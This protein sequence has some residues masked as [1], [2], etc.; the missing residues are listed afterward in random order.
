MRSAGLV[1]CFLFCILS[2][3]FALSARALPEGTEGRTGQTEAARPTAAEPPV[4][5]LAS[6]CS[7]TPLL[8]S[9]K[10]VPSAPALWDPASLAAPEMGPELAIPPLELKTPA[11]VVSLSFFLGRGGDDIFAALHKDYAWRM[12]FKS[13][14]LGLG[15]YREIPISRTIGLQPYLGFVRSSAT[16]RPSDLYGARGSFEYRLTV[17]CV[18]LPLVLRFN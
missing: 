3:V 6:S 15:I 4:F 2:F 9:S 18:G 17:L 16:L 8:P 1:F 5:T 14:T 12:T 10:I 11:P 13:M 7:S